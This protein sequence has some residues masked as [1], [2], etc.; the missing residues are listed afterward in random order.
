MYC[1]N[2]GKQ[3][4]DCTNFCPGCGSQQSN[5]VNDVQ[6]K[7]AGMKSRKVIKKETASTK[8]L[9]FNTIAIFVIILLTLPIIFIPFI[10][11]IIKIIIIL[12]VIIYC[13]TIYKNISIM[14][15]LFLCICNDGI[16]G[17]GRKDNKAQAFDFD[18]DEITEIKPGPL[19]IGWITIQSRGNVY[20]CNVKDAPKV[21]AFIHRLMN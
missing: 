6:K 13:I 18:Y 21:I 4:D 12:P 17:V 16:Y 7:P 19:G 14:E 11:I 3:I 9:L 5:Q 20:T 8:A 2:C 10:T 1:I 15:Q